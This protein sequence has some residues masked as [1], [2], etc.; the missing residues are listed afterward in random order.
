MEDFEQ[1]KMFEVKVEVGDLDAALFPFE[2]N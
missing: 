1:A 2:M